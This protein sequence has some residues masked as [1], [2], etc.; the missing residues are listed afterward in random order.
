MPE[1]DKRDRRKV[2]FLPQNI[3]VMILMHYLSLLSVFKYVLTVKLGIL[4]IILTSSI[5]S[6]KGQMD[7]DNEIDYIFVLSELWETYKCNLFRVW[8]CD[9]KPCT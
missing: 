9:H 2:E 6:L 3:Q 7:P 1:N 5:N 8:L 4:D